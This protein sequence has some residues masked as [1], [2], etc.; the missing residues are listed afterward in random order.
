MYRKYI[1]KSA[2]QIIEIADDLIKQNDAK[3]LKIL[4]IEIGTRKK[5]AKMLEATLNKINIFLAKSNQPINIGNNHQTKETETET[6]IETE[7]IERIDINNISD[8]STNDE[9]PRETSI[10]E[11][12]KS[13]SYLTD[14]PSHYEFSRKGKGIAGFSKTEFDKF[15]WAQKFFYSLDDWIDE[16]KKTSFGKSIDLLPGKIL[17]EIEQNDQNYLYI[18]P[19]LTAAEDIFENARVTLRI[20]SQKA[21]G[22]IVSITTGKNSSISITTDH[23]FGEKTQPGK[24]IVD[25]TAIIESLRDRIGNEIGLSKKQNGEKSIDNSL[26]LNFKFAENFIN[27]KFDYIDA[28]Y[29]EK[30]L[31]LNDSQNSFLSKAISSDISYLWGPPGTGKTQ[32]LTSL[33]ETFCENNERTLICSNT[34]MAV[35]Q[36]F[37]KLARKEDNKNVKQGKIIR[38]GRI[39]NDDLRD[40]F[41]D[42]VSLEGI[43]DVRAKEF[44]KEINK[45]M[46]A[47]E[48]AESKNRDL[49]IINKLFKEID[50]LNQK[51]KRLKN[52]YKDLEIELNEKRD[53]IDN[54]ERENEGLLEKYN[55]R[56]EGK[57]GLRGIFG[58]SPEQLKIDISFNDQSIEKILKL[59]NKF[60]KNLS[61]I[62]A[63]VK[64]IDSLLDQIE[65]KTKDF[66]RR[67]ILIKVKNVQNE[68]NKFSADIQENEKKIEEIKKVVIDESIVIGTT[69]TKVFLSASDLNKFE[70]VIIDEASMGLLPMLYLASSLSN[71]RIIISGDF[72][73]L[74]PIFSSKN[75]DLNDLL[76]KNIFEITGIAEEARTNKLN[77]ETNLIMLDTQYRMHPNIC[78]LISEFMYKSNLK[79]IPQKSNKKN[80]ESQVLDSVVTTIIDTS[81][82]FPFSSNTNTGSKI[83]P[84]NALVARNIIKQLIENSPNYSLGYCAPFKGQIKIFNAISSEEILNEVSSGTV[85]S[86]QGDEKDIIIYDTVE[87]N[88]N[89]KT[90]HPFLT[91]TYP[92]AEGAKL[93]N[94][95]ISRTKKQI[96]FIVDMASFDKKL[97][98]NS[99]LREILF[100]CQSEG[101]V[102]DARKIINLET[103]TNELLK[104]YFQPKNFDFPLENTGM[105]NQDQFFP[106]LYND[107]TSAKEAIIIYSGFFTPQRIQ[108]MLP[109]LVLKIK[110]GVSVRIVVPSNETNGS[111]GKNQ[112]DACLKTIKALRQEGIVVDQRARFHQKAVL[113]DSD[114][115]W[116]GS[117]NPLSY[118][119][120]TLESMLTIREKGVCLE[121]AE[122]LSLKITSKRSNPKDWAKSENPICPVN[123]C[124]K[125]T[126]YRKSKFG[127][128]YPCENPNCSGKAKFY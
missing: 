118:S 21:E 125:Q 8:N 38:L 120:K 121:M 66:S 28:N 32:T 52:K 12:R 86:F 71:K 108:E 22:R 62:N 31:D 94:V 68:I 80:L 23:F 46:N 1:R 101:K 79:S 42:L 11:I 34:N 7:T 106:L 117:L 6:E 116:F 77:N 70:N 17:Q 87:A 69:L 61:D 48:N 122:S 113:I 89:N 126:I 16:L 109:K 115:A 60:R 112:P 83:N 124:G 119:G 102:I 18:F 128:Y 5:R 67:E 50:T 105:V 26:G 84:L 27:N 44:K 19:I 78:N 13:G 47:K 98:N 99:F 97:P 95:A 14:V 43:C 20:G 41:F 90:L 96:I 36:V 85:H 15:N 29:F 82:V 110:E 55:L 25:N 51:R 92:E 64:E 111:F 123:G 57:G 2:K 10:H 103:I 9:G 88:S 114:V 4:K 37:L 49:L 93:L 58:R 75:Q 45:L 54:L 91:S 35:D 72:A 33:I 59:I 104:S 53:N 73:Q 100:K 76:G 81:T 74:S 39:F 56:I 65:E 24:I 127:E 63:E 30:K 40:N 107:I 3:E